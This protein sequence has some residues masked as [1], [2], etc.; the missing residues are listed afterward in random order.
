MQESN[1]VFYTQSASTVISEWAMLQ[2]GAVFP[3]LFICCSWKQSTCLDWRN[4]K[5]MVLTL[6]VRSNTCPEAYGLPC[7][8]RDA[9]GTRWM[10]HS[11]YMSEWSRLLRKRV[12]GEPNR[13]WMRITVRNQSWRFAASW[14]MSHIDF[15]WIQMVPIFPN[16][17]GEGLVFYRLLP[18]PCSLIS[19]VMLSFRL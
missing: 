2:E 10:A 8:D 5:V 9:A 12:A 19:C 17:V 6:A 16:R 1:W 3:G 15:L 11:V 13:I 7:N 14:V 18:C 4:S